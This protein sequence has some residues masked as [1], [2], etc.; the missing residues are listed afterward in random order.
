MP[1]PDDLT[2]D[3]IR[4]YIKFEL[5]GKKVPISKTVEK[6]LK[7]Y[8]TVGIKTRI[9]GHISYWKK[10]LAASSLTSIEDCII[11]QFGKKI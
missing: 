2:V 6:W 7:D 4:E 10:E 9:E 8:D 11:G 1:Y 3:A 5:S